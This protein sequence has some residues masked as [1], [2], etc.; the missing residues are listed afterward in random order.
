[1]DENKK[2]PNREFADAVSEDSMISKGVY[3]KAKR[4]QNPE[5][6]TL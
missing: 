3:L 6:E 4:A 5:Y 2:Q 1:M